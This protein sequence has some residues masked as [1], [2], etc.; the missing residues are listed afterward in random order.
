M[1]DVAVIVCYGGEGYTLGCVSP[2][3]GC[4]GEVALWVWYE[5]KAAQCGGKFGDEEGFEIPAAVD[6][7]YIDEL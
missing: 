3:R 5:G 6:G 7:D 1:H 2:T 4:E